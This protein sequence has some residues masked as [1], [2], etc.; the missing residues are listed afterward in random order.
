[1]KYRSRSTRAKKL[2]FI[3]SG[4]LLLGKPLF[5][6]Y[7]TYLT[8]KSPGKY[9]FY[10]V[11]LLRNLEK[12]YLA[13]CRVFSKNSCPLS[14]LLMFSGRKIESIRSGLGCSSPTVSRFN[15][16]ALFVSIILIVY[17]S[18][19]TRAWAHA[20]VNYKYFVT[21]RVVDNINSSSCSGFWPTIGL[22]IFFS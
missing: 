1:M 12:A 9:L 5:F 16:Y 10:F 7:A 11:K 14:P 17:Y 8:D 6:Y 20:H 2:S 22:Q 3:T 4:Y 18:W 21:S 15:R 13:N 19:T